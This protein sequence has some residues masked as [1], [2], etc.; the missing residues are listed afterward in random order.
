MKYMNESERL[1]AIFGVLLVVSA[2]AL[3][4]TTEVLTRRELAEHRRLVAAGAVSRVGRPSYQHHI[5]LEEQTL[6]DRWS[7]PDGH[8]ALGAGFS[9]FGLLL[10]FVP[11]TTSRKRVSGAMAAIDPAPESRASP[12]QPR[13]G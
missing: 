8:A 2:I 4:V 13:A 9:V 12:L 7:V 11:R 10:V 1:L 3:S 5:Y 6:A